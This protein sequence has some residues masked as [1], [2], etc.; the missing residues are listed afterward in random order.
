M[1]VYTSVSLFSAHAEVFPVYHYIAV[2]GYAL[3]RTRGGIS[4]FE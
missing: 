3:L 2:M 1:A 4:S